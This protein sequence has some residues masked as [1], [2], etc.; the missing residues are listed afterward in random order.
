M[1]FRSVSQ[2]RYPGHIVNGNNEF[3]VGSYASNST[4]PANISN[5]AFTGNRRFSVGIGSSSGQRKNAITVFEN[6]NTLF[7]GKVMTTDTAFLLNASI[8]HDLKIAGKIDVQQQLTVSDDFVLGSDNQAGK[9]KLIDQSGNWY[10]GF[11]TGTQS[12]NITLRYLCMAN[13]SDLF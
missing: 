9:I 7:Q 10:T 2:S 13:E 8:A 11:T 1:L 3:V 12:Q 5:T 6:G 4:N